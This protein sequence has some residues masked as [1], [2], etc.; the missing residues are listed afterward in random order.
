MSRLGLIIDP[1]A[2]LEIEMD[3]SLLVIAECN[4]RGHEVLIAT[5]D[6]LFLEGGQA[7]ATWQEIDYI[8]KKETLLTTISP[9]FKARL[10]DCDLIFMRKDPPFDTAYLASTYILDYANTIVINSPSGL[11]EVNEKL[12]VLRC[13][14]ITPKAFV[15]RNIAEIKSTI[16]QIGIKQWVVKPL[17]RRSGEAVFQFSVDQDNYSDLLNRVTKGQQEFVILQ[18][19]L[20]EVY[21]GDK[22]VFLVDGEPIGV[23]NRIPPARDFRANIHL[24]ATPLPTTLTERDSY[25]IKMISHALSKVDVPIACLD[26]IGGFLTEVNVTSP[27]GLPEIN[28]VNQAHYEGKIVDYLERRIQERI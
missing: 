5:L 21:A 26:I 10:A 4:K 8:G 9:D 18:R 14:E 23:M 25:I 15:S 27:S 2:S 22:R 19:F 28:R 16:N 24:G 6:D 20:P 7:W 3:T 12:F 11:R 1:L 13:P 17:N